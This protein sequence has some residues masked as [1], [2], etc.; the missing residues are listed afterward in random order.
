MSKKMIKVDDL[1]VSPIVA[2]TRKIISNLS[3]TE[4]A[5]LK[6]A[7]DANDGSLRELVMEILRKDVV[8]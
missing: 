1:V 4:L 3:I 2:S 6:D 7:K 8:E 5:R